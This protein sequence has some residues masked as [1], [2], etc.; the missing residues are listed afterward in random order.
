VKNAKANAD[1]R[2]DIFTG[3]HDRA[4]AALAKAKAKS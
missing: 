2:L 1:P 3:N 4:A